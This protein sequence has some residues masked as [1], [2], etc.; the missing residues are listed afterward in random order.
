[1]SHYETNLDKNKAVYCQKPLARH[2]SEVRE[3]R[4]IAEEKNLITQMTKP[5]KRKYDVL[6][7]RSKVGFVNR[8]GGS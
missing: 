3:M 5:V 4:K 1:M 7:E 2:V 8:V 6:L